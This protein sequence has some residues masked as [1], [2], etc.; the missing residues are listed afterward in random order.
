MMLCTEIMLLTM[1]VSLNTEMDVIDHRNEV[2]L[3]I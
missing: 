3:N 1:L 2:R